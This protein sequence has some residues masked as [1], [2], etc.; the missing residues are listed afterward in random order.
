MCP[1]GNELELLFCGG[2]FWCGGNEKNCPFVTEPYIY[3]SFIALSRT[4]MKSSAELWVGSACLSNFNFSSSGDD[5]DDETELSLLTSHLSLSP[6]GGCTGGYV[7]WSCV[8]GASILRVD[9]RG[10][11]LRKKANLHSLINLG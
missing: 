4:T 8:G 11:C 9:I 6:E 3:V 5:N 1:Y 2:F 10:I 7:L